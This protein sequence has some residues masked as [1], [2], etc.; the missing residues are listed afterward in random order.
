MFGVDSETWDA[1]ITSLFDPERQRA[2]AGFVNSMQA[3]N[4]FLSE[5]VPPR[6]DQPGDDLLSL[7]IAPD[8]HGDRLSDLELVANSVLLVTAGFETTMSLITLAARAL[9]RHPDQR[10]RLEDDWS[11]GANV[12]DEVLR[13]D[14]PALFT[15]RYATVDI[16][17][18]GTTKIGRAHF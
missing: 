14:P 4:Q 11:L 1:E 18:A 6:R 5:Y 17:V 2:G 3:L 8:E 13:F 10:A 16:A 7:L 12:V 15:T 9:L